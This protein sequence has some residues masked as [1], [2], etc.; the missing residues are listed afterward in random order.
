MVS[1]LS[2]FDSFQPKPTALSNTNTSSLNSLVQVNRGLP[3]CIAINN[4]G[5]RLLIGSEA[6]EK[7]EKISRTESQ[8]KLPKS[9]V[10]PVRVG[11]NNKGEVNKIDLS[12]DAKKDLES[13]APNTKLTD[14]PVYMKMKG[15]EKHYLKS[16]NVEYGTLTKE[17]QS[18]IEKAFAQY[19][20]EYRAVKLQLAEEKK[21]GAAEREQGRDLHKKGT[22]SAPKNVGEQIRRRLELQDDEKKARRSTEAH[23]HSKSEE[24]TASR[25]TAT[26]KNE[27]KRL[28]KEL[29]D[30]RILIEEKV[31][32]DEHI[33][34]E[35]SITSKVKK[36]RNLD[37]GLPPEQNRTK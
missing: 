23:V 15:G 8:G 9:K 5:V 36:N 19:L 27:S 3:G 14:V 18:H 11:Y 34:A 12:E 16:E 25:E 30:K 2:A 32:K 21:Q 29:E 6:A 4:T 7:T 35:G 37:E 28:E 10:W 24:I 1:K 13:R 31:A 17:E 26:K 20:D 33:K 22:D